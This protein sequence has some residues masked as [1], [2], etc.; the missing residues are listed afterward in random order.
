MLLQDA[1]ACPPPVLTPPKPL[2]SLDR[3][4]PLLCAPAVPDGGSEKQVVLVGIQHC[5]GLSE[6]GR[7][8]GLGCAA[9]QDA[10]WDR[11]TGFGP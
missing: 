11:T 9:E 7:C 8:A 5:D 6:S 2:Q 3:A 4:V 10:A 1:N